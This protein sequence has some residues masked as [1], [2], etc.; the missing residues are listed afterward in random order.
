LIAAPF[1]LPG[2]IASKRV[3]TCL[4]GVLLFAFITAGMLAWW[5]VA[6]MYGK[7]FEG[8]SP[9]GPHEDYVV[10]YSAGRL[11]RERNPAGLYDIPTIANTEVKSMGRS[12]GGTGVLAFF[13][14]PFVAA[15][16]APISA[17]PIEKAAV[18]IGTSCTGL[19]I[20]S[21]FL[22]QR[23][24]GLKERLHLLLFWLWFLSLHSL[25]WVVLHGQ[26]SLL[27]LLGWLLFIVLQVKGREKLSGLALALLLVK[28]QM[29][30][31]PVA[32]LL[33]KRRWYTLATF[34]TA[35]WGL[36]MVSVAISG[37]S[38]ISEYPRFLLQS[39]EW[40]GKWGV[41]PL[42]MFGWN[43]F[44]A[45][46]V[47]NSSASHLA[48]TL[49]L[50]AATAF[51]AVLCFR[52]KWEPEK[53]RFLLQ[54]AALLAAS[55][56]T[57]FHLYMQDLS[58]LA[59]VVVLGIAYALRTKTALHVWLA[60]ALLTWMA[61][62]WGLRLLD[63]HDLNILT[64]MT[65]LLLL[66][67]AY[68]LRTKPQAATQPAAATAKPAE[69]NLVLLLQLAYVG[70]IGA[71]CVIRETFL[72]PDVIFL[73]LLFGFVWG[74]QRVQF[75]RDFA[76]F[77]LLLLSYD[78]L[79]G[80]ADDLATSVRVGY[81]IAIDRFL[82][83]GHVPAQD[84]QRWLADEGVRHWY[85]SMAA[86]LHVAHFVV[87]LLFA[88]LIWLNRRGEYWRFM[89]ALLLLSY[90]AFVTFLL[91][92]TAP[93]WWASNNGYLDGVSII[94]LSSHTAFLY[95]K[96]GPNPVAA[97]PSLH[98]AY[99]W[100][101]FLFACRLW[102]KRG[103]LTVVYPAAVFFSI[104]YLGHHYVA[105]IIGGVLYASASYVLVCGPV[106]QRVAR[107]RWAFPFDFAGGRR[108][109][110]AQGALAGTIMNADNARLAPHVRVPTPVSP[111]EGGR[112]EQEP[113]P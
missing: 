108:A 37:P 51:V 64:P 92:P 82:F 71:L 34:A 55:L 110:G 5:D 29:A 30:I 86:L 74:K 47:D 87:P 36:A 85:D 43:G 28:P 70:F 46:F 68:T 91:L 106:G 48:T 1:S 53:P 76:P 27:M 113:A 58:L 3:L 19:A 112:Q 22:L 33:W 9:Q 15:P 13:N 14:P 75:V 31:L 100:L 16:F 83:F 78:A 59:L 38:I 42:G 44:V 18:L 2:L 65:A 56:L 35:A 32:V 97:M 57:N 89:A 61:Q 52:G 25:A 79:R 62:Q 99:P 77:V 66:G 103:A 94:H 12:V 63:D 95:D 7:R 60:L 93:P 72:M 96:V 23:L 26:L 80:F 81:P 54:C 102:G 84:L 17:L 67:A 24:L 88:A 109:T 21:G 40:Q 20:L 69:Y 41:S 11:V 50:D 98:A 49:A 6:D 8:R 39:T 105:D 111:G 90:A 101:F 45:H 73:L 107:M 104:V 10:F 4:L